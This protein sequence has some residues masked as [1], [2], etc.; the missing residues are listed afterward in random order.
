METPLGSPRLE[1]NCRCDPFQFRGRAHPQSSRFPKPYRQEH[2]GSPQHP[3]AN[4]K[5]RW[6]RYF[7]DLN[8]SARVPREGSD[9][10][11]KTR[12]SLSSVGIPTPA[13]TVCPIAVNTPVEGSL[14]SALPRRTKTFPPVINT[15]PF[16]SLVAAWKYR[17]VIILPVV[18][19]VPAVCAVAAD[20]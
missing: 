1:R 6:K 18:A 8:S 20:V 5:R 10:I 11:I 17:G 12:P 16:S 2:H 4:S 9:P 7:P 13:M 19:N 15:W 14:R 3:F